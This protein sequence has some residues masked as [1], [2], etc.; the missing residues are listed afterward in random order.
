VLSIRAHLRRQDEISTIAA[1]I[2][3]P[4]A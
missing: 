1:A 4:A 2:V 3:H